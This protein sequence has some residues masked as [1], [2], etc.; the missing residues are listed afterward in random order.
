MPISKDWFPKSRALQLSMAKDWIHVLTAATLERW[1]IPPEEYDALE[2]LMEE[3]ELILNKA[4]SSE[5]T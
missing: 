4:M 5:R 2:T 3:A 1:K